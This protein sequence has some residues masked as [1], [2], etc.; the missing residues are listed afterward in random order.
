MKIIRFLILVLFSSYLFS[1]EL[2]SDLVKLAQNNPELLKGINKEPIAQKEILNEDI[3]IDSQLSDQSNQDESGLEDFKKKFGFDFIKTIPKSISSTSD[4]PVPNDYLL[5]LGDSL[6]VIL[7]GNR[8]EIY[9]L[10]VGL[11][12]AILF[13]ELGSINVFGDSIKDVRDK[14]ESLISIS[15]VGTD[16]S[17]SLSKL[18]AKKINII[19]AVR[20]PGTYI[21]NPFST[22]TSAL[23]YSGG[24]LEYA[25]VRQITIFREGVKIDFDLYDLLIFGNRDSDINLQQG[26]TILVNSTS[27]FIEV[28]GSINRPHIYEYTENENVEDIIGFAMGLTQY[29]NSNKIALTY[30]NKSLETTEIIEVAYTDKKN[31]TKFNIPLKIEVFEASSSE[32][33]GIKVTGPLENQGYFSIPKSGLLID[34]IKELEFTENVNPYIAVLEDRNRSELFSLADDSTQDLKISS[35]TNLYF[36]DIFD[37]D[38]SESNLSSNTLKLILDYQLTINYDGKQIFFP[39]YGKID[40]INIVDQLGLDIT[41]ALTSQTTYISPLDE[42]VLVDNIE[43]L[44]FTASKYNYLTIK[45]LVD[46]TIKVTV[47]GEATLPGIYT[48]IPGTSLAELYEMVQ[49]VKKSGD[50]NT[51]VFTR[52]S[53]KKQNIKNLRNAQNSLRKTILSSNETADPNL[54]LMLEK[55]IDEDLLGRISG[56]LGPNSKSIE[57]FLLED[58]DELF[59]PKQ[60]YTVSV[61]GEVLNPSS[62]IYKEDMTF[63]DLISLSGG[64][65]QNS[66]KSATYVIRSNGEVV[67]SSGIFNRNVK[68]NPGDTIVV[69]A[70]LNENQDIVSLLAP[71]TSIL[72]N[73]AFSAAA[74]DNLR[75]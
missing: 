39:F 11:D 73:L 74:I 72:S 5:S 16:V 7:T 24:F 64:Y 59:V 21:V 36:F 56:D 53:I 23:A 22:I 37:N 62:F 65:T 75:Q 28:S 47:S 61:I 49:G 60:I 4:L 8:K 3:S 18:A 30:L 52:E 25:S 38:F 57:K 71:I 6:K 51:V 20:S 54:M 45:S 44:S 67:N 27:N 66:L 40:A 43:D 26:D 2:D 32:N 50:Q 69:P 48:L 34:L 14:I 13:P 70:N 31:I 42:V 41:G 12:G 19:G 58:G 9:E 10:E 29:A 15:Y 55:E 46:Q 63:K 17:V 1:Q 33:M 68:I 35:N